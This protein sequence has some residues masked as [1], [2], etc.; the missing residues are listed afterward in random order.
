MGHNARSNLA[1]R[2]CA[3][4]QIAAFRAPIAVE[5]QRCEALLE[6][7]V[8]ALVSALNQVADLEFATWSNDQ[9]LC[10]EAISTF[11][12]E[13]QARRFL[14]VRRNA[15]PD[16]TYKRCL[17]ALSFLLQRTRTMSCKKRSHRLTVPMRSRRAQREVS[18]VAKHP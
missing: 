3:A 15:R 14:Q 11:S 8:A 18:Q 2:Q 9:A 10:M 17:K 7:E 1:A 4:S 6:E 13:V 12:R 5:A 16:F